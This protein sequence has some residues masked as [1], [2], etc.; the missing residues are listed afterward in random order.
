MTFITVTDQAGKVRRSMTNGLGQ[1]AR[2][3]E[4]DANGNL[5]TADSPAQPTSYSYDGLGNLTTVNQG[6]QTRS[7]VYSSLSR[8]TSATNPESGTISYQYDANGN[9]TRKTDARGVY[10]DYAYDALNRAN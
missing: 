9:L 5:G 1:L 2:I 8:L 10:I 7:F 3:D 6:V 4:P